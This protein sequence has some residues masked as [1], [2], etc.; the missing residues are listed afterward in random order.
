MNQILL[1][2]SVAISSIFL[3]SQITEGVLLVPYWKSIS[4]IEFYE[5]Y[6]VIGNSIDRF[7]SILTIIALLIPIGLSIYCY[8]IKSRALKYSLVS[9][10]FALMVI[11]VFY[12]YF[13]DANQQFYTAT[14]N[15]SELKSLLNNWEYWHWIRVLFEIISL[16]F[17]IQT[18]AIL[19]NNISE[20]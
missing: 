9:T 2:L 17:L 4:S 16:I 8:Q 1:L 10:F 5:H 18:V 15:S 3:G 12:L 11:A 19:N 6:A 7:F 20:N 13:K 14:L